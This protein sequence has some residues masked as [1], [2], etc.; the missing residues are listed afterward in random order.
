VTRTTREREYFKAYYVANRKTIK[1]RSSA[2][3]KAN[4]EHHKELKRAHVLAHPEDYKKQRDAW[5]AE[6][7]EITITRA[8]EWN[9]AH[10]ATFHKRCL[11]Q[12]AKRRARLRSVKTETIYPAI[13]WDREEGLCGIC[14][15]P[16]DP[17][18]WHLDHAIPLA[19]GGEHTY[20]NVQVSHP[21]CNWKKGAR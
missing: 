1:K 15:K 14:G 2:H 7:R 4:R 16:A 18:N 10:L 5:Y 20:A 19:R 12:N 8:T 13:V 11:V 9:K 21:E 3:Y 6:H 17:D